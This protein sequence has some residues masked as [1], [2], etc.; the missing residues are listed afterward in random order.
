M[1]LSAINTRVGLYFHLKS[2]FFFISLY[3]L[4]NTNNI[5]VEKK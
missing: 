3:L 5:N 1:T 2:D 4:H